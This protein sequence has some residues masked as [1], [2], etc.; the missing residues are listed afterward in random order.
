MARGFLNINAHEV[1]LHTQRLEKLHRS[2]LPLAVRD[3]LNGLAFKTKTETMPREAQRAFIQ[4]TRNF[5]KYNSRVK[6]ATGWNIN[7]MRAV[8]GFINGDKWQA[9]KDLETQEHGGRIGGRSFIPLKGARTGKKHNR[10]VSRKF[11]LGKIS[12][13]VSVNDVRGKSYKQR[14]VKAA[15]E[16]TEGGYVITENTLYKVKRLKRKG[17]NTQLK[18]MPLYSYKS[19]RS[20]NIRKPKKFMQKANKE[21][22]K[23]LE[24]LYIYYANKQI[25]RLG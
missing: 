18:L 3:T 22:M 20:A 12:N 9:V 4:R 5:F 21:T 16:A 13:A 14:V 11:R 24:K 2:A 17:R 15:V 19:N 7:E 6:R 1:V 8:F 25:K 23:D 10:L